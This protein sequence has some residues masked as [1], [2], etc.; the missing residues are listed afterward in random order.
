MT[1]TVIMCLILPAAILV[2][3]AAIMTRTKGR[4]VRRPDAGDEENWL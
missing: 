2:A 4:D 3:M 1:T